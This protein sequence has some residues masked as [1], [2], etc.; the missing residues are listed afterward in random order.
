METSARRIARTTLVAAAALVLATAFGSSARA[1]TEIPPPTGT[2]I[3]DCFGNLL[4]KPF[5]IYASSGSPNAAGGF[6]VQGTSGNDVIIGSSGP[7]YI[8][9]NG[10]DDIICGGDGDDH[11][12]GGTYGASDSTTSDYDHIDGEN[13]DDTISGGP[14]TDVIYGGHGDDLVTGD[15]GADIIHGQ[16]GSDTLF[17]NDGADFIQCGSDNDSHKNPYYQP[18]PLLVMAG[19]YANGGGDTDVLPESVGLV[20]DCEHMEYIP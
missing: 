4:I 6:V 1:D 18:D 20:S 14:D 9:G 13:G 7:D 2:L 10:G 19:D 11:L 17:G 16:G 3:T 5:V 12:W 15:D 8:Y